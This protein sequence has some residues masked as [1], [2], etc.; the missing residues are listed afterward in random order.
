MHASD[1]HEHRNRTKDREAEIERTVEQ[2]HDCNQ[3]A[4]AALRLDPLDLV[5]DHQ[6]QREQRPLQ[7]CHL[8]DT[9]ESAG[10]RRILPE[11]FCSCE[12]TQLRAMDV[13]QTPAAVQTV[14]P[15]EVAPQP[16][17]ADVPEAPAPAPTAPQPIKTETADV[18]PTVQQQPGDTTLAQTPTEAQPAQQ[19]S[20]AQPQ[21][22]AD[23]PAEASAAAAS[24][25]TASSPSQGQKV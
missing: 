13:D 20:V 1:H 9:S 4:H 6:V 17:H 8:L 15:A 2:W 24:A 10:A 16:P 14:A 12:H 11:I 23:T 21:A 19:S 7:H 22:P 3:C 25:A 5:R 18:P